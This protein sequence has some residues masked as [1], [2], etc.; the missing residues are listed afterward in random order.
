MRC[1]GWKAWYTGG[2]KFDSSRTA[3]ADLPDDGALAIVIYFDERSADRLPQRR[4]MTG[5]DYYFRDGDI[6]GQN[7]ETAEDNRRRYPNASFKRGKWTTDDEMQRINAEL[8]L[9][10]I[11]P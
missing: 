8:T 2:R 4:I 10:R 1:I 7:N 11:P 6:Y 5:S 9:A 3:W